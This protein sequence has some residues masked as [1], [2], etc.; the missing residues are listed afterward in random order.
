MAKRMIT[1]RG[2]P[3]LRRSTSCR[4]T[5]RFTQS[6][7]FEIGQAAAPYVLA[8]GLIAASFL[9]LVVI[10]LGSAWGLVEAIG[11]G[12]QRFFWV[13]LVESLP[14]LIVP[15]LLP[16]L[17]SLAIHLMGYSCSFCLDQA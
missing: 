5:L 6:T 4:P 16:G 7:M 11:W 17:F 12:R 14:A 3:T 2:N 10:S 8:V 9:A 1:C 13:Y 15:I